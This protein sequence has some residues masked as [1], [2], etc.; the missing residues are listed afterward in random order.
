MGGVDTVLY[1]TGEA[2]IIGGD[3]S[4]VRR[5]P[6]AVSLFLPFRLRRRLSQLSTQVRASS[7]GFGRQSSIS[8]RA[9]PTHVPGLLR[10]LCHYYLANLLPH[11]RTF[12]TTSGPQ[13]RRPLSIWIC[14]FEPCHDP[15][16]V[17]GCWTTGADQARITGQWPPQTSSAARG[18]I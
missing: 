12:C 2:K 16:L 4:A 1:R 6:C 9:R 5:R 18:R 17:Q 15:S 7:T 13:D 14:V 8:Y 3:R 10:A 11:L